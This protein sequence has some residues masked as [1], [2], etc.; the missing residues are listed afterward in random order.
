LLVILTKCTKLP[1]LAPVGG[2]ITARQM[3]RSINS[4]NLCL[5]RQIS[6]SI[7][8]SAVDSDSSGIEIGQ[9][10]QNLLDSVVE[11]RSPVLKYKPKASRAL[12]AEKLSTKLDCAVSV[13]DDK[14]K[15]V[16]FGIY[17][18]DR[19]AT[20]CIGKPFSAPLC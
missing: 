3:S 16:N 17:V 8:H 1:P 9:R 12:A 6:P 4:V 7:N 11:A 14:V 20:T 13:P 19:K 10:Q 15:K 2:S 18:A 5:T